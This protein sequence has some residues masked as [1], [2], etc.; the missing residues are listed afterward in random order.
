LQSIRGRCRGLRW[1]QE[2]G[3]VLRPKKVIHEVVAE[4]EVARKA[5]A[6]KIITAIG[7]KSCTSRHT[8][9]MAT[10]L[11]TRGRRVWMTNNSISGAFGHIWDFWF[12][13]Y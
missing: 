1:R 3:W 6:S 4:S 10:L 8:Y 9:M 13:A 7:A 11:R 5:A 2:G 12:V